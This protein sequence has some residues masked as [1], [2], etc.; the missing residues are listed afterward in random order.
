MYTNKNTIDAKIKDMTMMIATTSQQ[1]ASKSL[2]ALLRSATS[3]QCQNINHICFQNALNAGYSVDYLIH[4]ISVA[5]PAKKRILRMSAIE[6]M[7]L[8]YQSRFRFLDAQMER[9]S[10]RVKVKVS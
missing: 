10:V 2:A 8:T 9:K 6:E 3:N 4:R 7:I 1:E 5:L